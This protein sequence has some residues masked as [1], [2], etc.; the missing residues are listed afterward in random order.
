MTPG[1]DVFYEMFEITSRYI[2]VNVYSL[3]LGLVAFLF[4]LHLGIVIV[5]PIVGLF[6]NYLVRFID[7]EGLTS[8]WE[9]YTEGK[10]LGQDIFHLILY[11]LYIIVIYWSGVYVRNDKRK[12]VKTLANA[13]VVVVKRAYSL[14][15]DDVSSFEEH[16]ETWPRLYNWAPIFVYRLWRNKIESFVKERDRNRIIKGA[17]ESAAENVIVNNESTPLIGV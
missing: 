13:I 9:N 1:P 16:C 10:T 4:G 2:T 12:A 7:L 17:K 6:F 11:S 8:T 3:I 5:L 15:D 14:G